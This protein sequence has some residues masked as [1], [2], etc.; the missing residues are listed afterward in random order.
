MNAIGQRHVDGG[1]MGL[2]TLSLDHDGLEAFYDNPNALRAYFR[3]IG[4]M[5]LAAEGLERRAKPAGGG[6][7]RCSAER[8]T[9]QADLEPVEQGWRA[10]QAGAAE[11]RDEL[12]AGRVSAG[13]GIHHGARESSGDLVRTGD[14]DI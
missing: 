12:D 10:A 11:A 8:R 4:R 13:G 9:K 6:L 2:G 3:N 7:Y 14:S 1:F 5:V